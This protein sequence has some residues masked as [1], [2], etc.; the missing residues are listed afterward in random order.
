MAI[1]KRTPRIGQATNQLLPKSASSQVSSS[2]GTSSNSNSNYT[3]SSSSIGNNMS[4]NKST[5][6]ILLGM[7]CSH[8]IT[9]KFEEIVCSISRIDLST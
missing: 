1:A 3:I 6:L 8:L 4:K 2:A 5:L 9:G 7:P